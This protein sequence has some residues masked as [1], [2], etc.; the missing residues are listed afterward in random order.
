MENKEKSIKTSLGRAQCIQ[1][2]FMEIRCT[3][4]HT[5]LK[6]P[7]FCKKKKYDHEET[8]VTAQQAVTNLSHMHIWFS[9]YW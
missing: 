2:A 4:S 7:T 9:F 1:S 5:A 6:S 3:T 8:T